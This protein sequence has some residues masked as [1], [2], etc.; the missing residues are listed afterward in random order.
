MQARSVCLI[1]YL[2]GCHRRAGDEMREVRQQNSGGGVGGGGADGEVLEILEQI[3]VQVRPR[4]GF[5]S[6]V[7]VVVSVIFH[8][9]NLQVVSHAND[10]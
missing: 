4:A 5:F 6:L 10:P 9:S 7:V 1:S 3:K 2:G 8:V